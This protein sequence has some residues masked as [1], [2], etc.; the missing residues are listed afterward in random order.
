M[1]KQTRKI[2]IGVIGVAA[3]AAVAVSFWGGSSDGDM[4]VSV[5]IQ[6]DQLLG[7]GADIVDENTRQY[8][9]EDGY[10]LKE[11]KVSLAE[12]ANAFDALKK[13]CDENEIA[14]DYEDA[15]YG[16]YVK[17][18]NYLYEV[19]TD[20]SYAG[21]MYNV[22]DEEASVSASEY[23]LEAGDDVLWYYSSMTF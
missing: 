14:L 19:S 8:I 1:K 22:N 4:E 7:E 2:V 16:A 9:P 20:N 10:V 15:S 23:E 6:C 21:W 17:G 3:V 18:I 13:A 5:T 11:I 12:G